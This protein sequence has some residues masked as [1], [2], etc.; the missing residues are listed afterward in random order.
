MIDS[1]CHLDL[2]E[3]NGRRDEVIAEAVRAGVH[4]LVNIGADLESSRRSVALAERFDSVYAA[5]GVHPH[6]AKTVDDNVLDELKKMTEHEKVVAIGEIGLDYYRDLSPRDVQR[7][8]FV[9]Q[10]ELAVDLDMPIVIHTREA[11]RDTV[12]IVRPYAPALVGGV[13]HCFP[14]NAREAKEVL[15]LGFHVS[16]GGR[17][18]YK[19]ALS[20]VMATA[21]PLEKILLETDAPFLTPVP[22]RGKTNSPAYIPY[23]CRKL[24]ELK[25]IDPAEVEKVTDRNTQKLFHLVETFGG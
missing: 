15:D 4:T 3:Y 10:L 8:A 11:F 19:N 9:Q 23:I 24:A 18:T 16:V 2:K 25:G 7:R 21:V 5:V 13:F 14:G 20:A 6:D 22:F 17:I 1:H 12:D